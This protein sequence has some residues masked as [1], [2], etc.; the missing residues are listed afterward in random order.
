MGLDHHLPAQDNRVLRSAFRGSIEP[1]EDEQVLPIAEGEDVFKELRDRKYLRSLG[2][3]MPRPWLDGVLDDAQQLQC[4]WQAFFAQF[5]GQ[6]PAKRAH[7]LPWS[8]AFPEPKNW[9][10]AYLL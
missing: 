2:D 9:K 10:I 7:T 1:H 3:A 5:A 4:C 6:R 8:S